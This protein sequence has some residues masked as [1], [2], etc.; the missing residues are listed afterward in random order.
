MAGR[1]LVA[2]PTV[3]FPL[4]APLPRGARHPPA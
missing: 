1:L 2:P 4:R 3:S